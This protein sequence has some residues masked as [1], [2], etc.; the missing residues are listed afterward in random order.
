MN[1]VIHHP[2][3]DKCIFSHPESE[4]A[5]TQREYGRDAKRRH[6]NCRAKIRSISR[7]LE[8]QG[9]TPRQ[10]EQQAEGGA[11]ASGSR[12]ET[13]EVLQPAAMAGGHGS[14]TEEVLQPGSFGNIPCWR[15][16]A[17]ASESDWSKEL[18]ELHNLDDSEGEDTHRIWRT[19]SELAFPSATALPARNT[20]KSRLVRVGRKSSESSQ[21]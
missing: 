7:R 2:N 6:A 13:E 14:E 12:G 4:A 10:E 16:I 18:Q 1:L 5:S 20:E 8:S 9:L 3:G 11:V 17:G 19:A 15:R 21:K